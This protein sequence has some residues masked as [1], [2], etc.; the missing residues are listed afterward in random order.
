MEGLLDS[1]RS[2][3]TELAQATSKEHRLDI[4]AH[5]Q[6]AYD[7]LGGLLRELDGAEKAGA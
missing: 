1:L 7:E 5:I 6:W 3:W 4:R 2:D